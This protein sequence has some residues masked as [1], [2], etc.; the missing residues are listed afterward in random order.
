MAHIVQR[1]T[2]FG[3]R[4]RCPALGRWR[5]KSVAD[6]REEAEQYLQAIEHEIA[7]FGRMPTLPVSG[8]TPLHQFVEPWIDDRRRRRLRT[9]DDDRAR[10]LNH[11]VPRLGRVPVK[12]I[13]VRDIRSLIADLQKTD[14][15]PRTVRQVYGILHKFFADLVVEEVIERTPCVLTKDQLPK[16]IDG[17][18]E[19]RAQAIF[20]R[21]EAEI[22]ISSQAIPPDRLAFYAILLF[23]GVRL[24][25]AA[26]L[27]WRDYDE[28]AEPLHRLTV[29]RSYDGRLK[30]EV[31]RQVAVH[32]VLAAILAEWRMGGFAAIMGRPP[33][34][35]DYIVPSR[36]G[37]I[38][39]PNQVR[40]KFLDDLKRLGL[41][42]RRVHDTRRTFITL[43]RVDGAA[44]DVLETM[45]HGPRGNIMNLYTTY[46]W[47]TLCEAIA[48]LNLRRVGGE[49]VRL[50]LT[51]LAVMG[52]GSRESGSAGIGVGEALAPADEPHPDG[53]VIPLVTAL[54]EKTRYV[55]K[56]WTKHAFSEAGNGGGGG[57]RIYA[58]KP[59]Q[60]VDFTTIVA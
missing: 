37:Q 33:R 17:D 19:W 41:R 52:G 1:G 12:D 51:N 27:R 15:A 59:R 54:A 2:R 55:H 28:R 26:G 38:R 40:G 45:T 60:P 10:L 3:V 35:D 46:P 56:S 53:L 44:R 32:P 30:T 18:P 20:T 7:N 29:A 25:E 4:Y 23:T 47:P 42:H 16:N 31:P 9:A 8:S 21:D 43:A 34:R 50:R 39:S 6:T 57:N 13:R 5:T 22:L 48:R 49:V 11:V 14:L 36:L 58:A 24:G